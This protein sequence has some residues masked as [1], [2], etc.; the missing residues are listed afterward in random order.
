MANI[1]FNL[2]YYV[3]SAAALAAANPV[4]TEG[5]IGV[6][7]DTGL[8]KIGDGVSSWNSLNYVIINDKQSVF[9]GISETAGNLLSFGEDGGLNVPQGLFPVYQDLVDG[10]LEDKVSNPNVV[11]GETANIHAYRQLVILV[12]KIIACLGSSY[13]VLR[14]PGGGGELVSLETL[15]TNSIQDKVTISDVIKDSTTSLDSTWSSQEINNFILSSTAT[16]ISNVVGNAPEALDTIYEIAARMQAD[17]STLEYLLTAVGG[18]VRFDKE[19]TLTSPQKAQARTNIDALSASAFGT[20]IDTITD[21]TFTD[22]FDQAF[23][24]ATTE[25]AVIRPAVC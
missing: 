9:I 11:E 8:F 12:G 18:A 6:E 23:N 13:T 15:L 24:T 25:V 2:S 20:D 21:S 17:G 22:L 10:L 1:N 3:D 5:R 14:T 16:A 4:L 7:T 19:M